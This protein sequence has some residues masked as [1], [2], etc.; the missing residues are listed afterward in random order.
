MSEN[1]GDVDQAYVVTTKIGS[2]MRL[3]DP[4]ARELDGRF[5]DAFPEEFCKR[6][7]I[8]RRWTDGTRVVEMTTT[9]TRPATQPPT[10]E[11]AEVAVADYRH[12]VERAGYRVID[13]PVVEMDTHGRESRWH[14]TVRGQCRPSPSRDLFGF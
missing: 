10:S 1:A 4:A 8:E 5:R 9:F 14:I 13:D 6:S 12:A 7:E 11:V 2:P 3:V